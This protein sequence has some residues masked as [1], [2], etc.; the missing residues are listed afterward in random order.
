MSKSTNIKKAKTSSKKRT[1]RL[2][3][4]PLTT[5][6]SQQLQPEV[7][8]RRISRRRW[9]GWSL[10]ALGIAGLAGVA[11][12]SSW[13][14][15]KATSDIPEGF[16][17][18]EGDHELLSYRV[19]ERYPH[20]EEAFTQGLVFHEGHLYEGTG[21][22]GESKLRKVNLETG[23]A[24]REHDLPSHCFGE[25]MTIWQDKIIQ[26]TWVAHP[27]Q[28]YTPRHQGYLP[29]YETYPRAPF[30]FVYDKNTFRLLRTIE[31]YPRG[32]REAW[33]LTHD[34][35][36]LILSDGSMILRYLDPETFQIVGNIQLRNLPTQ[37]WHAWELNELE[38][39][40]GQIY[41][42]VFQED[43]ILRIDPRTQSITGIL[44][45]RGLRPSRIT[46][47]NKVLNGIAHDG[48][49]DRLFVTGKQWPT[50]FEIELV[51][52]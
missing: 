6:S 42:N 34:G 25:G 22:Y 8:P 37:Y 15:E 5:N 13:W 52:L 51:T 49:N 43:F 30:A 14:N 36:N 9:L 45:L 41:A 35:Q 40:D 19:V 2:A 46:D 27:T 21:L 39:I 1:K 24:V 44:N 18:L 12:S 10:A 32:V 4:Q 3:S 26:L 28:V 47:F 31:S 7:A 48:T 33:G 11:V 29:E 38:F 20:D 50:L 17:S 23:Q 16:P